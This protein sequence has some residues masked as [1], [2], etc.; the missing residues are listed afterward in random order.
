MKIKVW[1]Y[2][3]IPFPFALLAIVMAL[4]LDSEYAV[5]WLMLG[6]LL[7]A[8]GIVLLDIL[9]IKS[10][11][12]ETEGNQRRFSKYCYIIYLCILCISLCFGDGVASVVYP[13]AALGFIVAVCVMRNVEKS[14]KY[15][16]LSMLRTI[17][18]AHF[19]GY[20]VYWVLMGVI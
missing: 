7:L 14:A 11:A 9:L 3:L 10:K 6:L 13:V 16:V 19:A 12:G 20:I 1:L 4:L 15:R 18:A 8:L 17:A 5:V 2:G